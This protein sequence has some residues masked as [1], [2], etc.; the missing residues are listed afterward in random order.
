MLDFN[1]VCLEVNPSIDRFDLAINRYT[2]ESLLCLLFL[3][4]LH[5]GLKVQLDNVISHLVL[6]LGW[7]HSVHLWLDLFHDVVS[8]LVD[9]GLAEHVC[10]GVTKDTNRCYR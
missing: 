10:L 1:R 8:N 2:E 9:V 4:L 3:D 6:D 5:Q 7:H